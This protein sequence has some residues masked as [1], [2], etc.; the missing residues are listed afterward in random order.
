MCFSPSTTSMAV[1]FEPTSEM[2]RNIAAI[3]ASSAAVERK[4]SMLTQAEQLTLKSKYCV[5]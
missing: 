1:T 2:E 4:G 5:V 3:L